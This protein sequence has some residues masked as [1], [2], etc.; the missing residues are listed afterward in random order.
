MRNSL[1]EKKTFQHSFIALWS[2]NPSRVL[3]GVLCG[4]LLLRKGAWFC[5]GVHQRF[6]KLEKVNRGENVY[7]RKRIGE[8]IRNNIY[9]KKCTQRSFIA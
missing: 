9:E 1:Y 3:K 4:S 6:A 8:R 7:G 5:F 2:S